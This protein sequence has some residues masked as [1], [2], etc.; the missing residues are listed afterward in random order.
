MKECERERERQQGTGIE[1]LIRRKENY[2]Y[3]CWSAWILFLGL[4][5]G[6]L[7]FQ[8]WRNF[9][10]AGTFD[11]GNRQCLTHGES[12]SYAEASAYAELM[13]KNLMEQA[14]LIKAKASTSRM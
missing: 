1:Q 2:S 10:L 6:V 13:K 3:T 5:A 7:A 14:Y 11:T 4:F 8:A 9:N 12:S